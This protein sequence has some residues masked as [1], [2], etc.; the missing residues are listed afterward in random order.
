MEKEFFKSQ[1]MR[2]RKNY[3]MDSYPLETI[4]S[5]WEN[6][7]HISPERFQKMIDRLL[8]THPNPK[9]PPG[10]DKMESILS[11][12]REDKWQE[13]KKKPITGNVKFEDIQKWAKKL[14]E[15]IS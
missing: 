15:E 5:I 6:T 13:Q 4:K 7:A 1:M 14:R 8:A 3:G 12:I 9:F 2:L 11:Q 10:L